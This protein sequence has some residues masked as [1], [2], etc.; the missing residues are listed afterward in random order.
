MSAAWSLPYYF[1]PLRREGGDWK[2][3]HSVA[4]PHHISIHS[5][6]RAETIFMT[7]KNGNRFD[8]NPL[9]REGGDFCWAC[10]APV[11]RDFNPLRREGGDSN[12]TQ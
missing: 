10:I 12:N 8:F 7:V 6:A 3:D 9:R 2:D 5:A 1:N 11:R 4:Y